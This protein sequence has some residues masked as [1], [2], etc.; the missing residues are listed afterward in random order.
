MWLCSLFV[1]VACTQQMEKT[2]S[3]A[4]DSQQIAWG[5]TLV[6][7]PTNKVWFNGETPMKQTLQ[8]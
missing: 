7:N 2:I 8:T 4:F 5:L 1:T 6:W 3:P